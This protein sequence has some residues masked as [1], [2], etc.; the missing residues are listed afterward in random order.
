M[1]FQATATLLEGTVLPSA[2][3]YSAYIWRNII[4][5]PVE[6]ILL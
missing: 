5:E 3:V 6:V 4:T 2:A 1:L